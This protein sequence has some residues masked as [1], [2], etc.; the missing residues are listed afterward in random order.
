MSHCFDVCRERQGVVQVHTKVLCTLGGR[1]CGV[2]NLDGEFLERAGLPCEKEQLCLVEVE[3]EVVGRH[4][5]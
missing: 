3:L 2:V 1:H 5:S 4:P